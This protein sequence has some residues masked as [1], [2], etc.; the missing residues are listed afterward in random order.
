MNMRRGGFTPK[1]PDLATEAEVAELSTYHACRNC[2]SGLKQAQKIYVANETSNVNNLT[3]RH[4]GRTFTAEGLGSPLLWRKSST[5]SP[6]KGSQQFRT[7]K[8][9]SYRWALGSGS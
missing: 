1:M 4:I 3:E 8:P 2:Q 6:S 9:V 5:R 7:I